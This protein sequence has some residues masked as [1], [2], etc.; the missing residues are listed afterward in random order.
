M[1]FCV[2]GLIKL[3]LGHFRKKCTLLIAYNSPNADLFMAI[4]PIIPTV[5]QFS[6]FLLT[7]MFLTG[8]TF[9][10]SGNPPLREPQDESQN[11]LAQ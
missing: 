11:L 1:G 3:Y 10:P 4:I 6:V 2:R 5:S 9:R 7:V 8:R